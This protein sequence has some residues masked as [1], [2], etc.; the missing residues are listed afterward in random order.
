V[1][2]AAIARDARPPDALIRVMNPVL[3][4]ILPT[5]L[6]RIIRPFA[7][8]DF[9][10]RRSGRRFRVPVGWHHTDSGDVVITP[11][12][13]RANFRDGLPVTVHHRGGRQDLIGTLATDPAHVAAE[14]RSLA[15]RQGS[16]A[17]VGIKAPR[18]HAITVADV[19][20]VDRA[21]IH[22]RPA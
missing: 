15:D 8:L 5:P 1:T 4:A 17:R 20:A 12:P 2:A 7:L 3:R 11:A 13:W 9:E 18:G 19:T 16:F 22:F 21:V 10:G 6:G 14:L